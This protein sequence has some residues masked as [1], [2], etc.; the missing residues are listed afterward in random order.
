MYSYPHFHRN[1]TILW[2]RDGEKE[3]EEVMLSFNAQ[4]VIIDLAFE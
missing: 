4:L 3:G 2:E 1:N